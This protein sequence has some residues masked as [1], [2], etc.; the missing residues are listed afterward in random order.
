MT[1]YAARAIIER[2][3]RNL[4]SGILIQSLTDFCKGQAEDVLSFLSGPRAALYVRSLDTEGLDQD[5]ERIAWQWLRE[6]IIAQDFDG[7]GWLKISQSREE[8]RHYDTEK[9]IDS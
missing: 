8:L 4:V 6:R 3:Y 1:D 7:R 5:Q 2:A 9:D